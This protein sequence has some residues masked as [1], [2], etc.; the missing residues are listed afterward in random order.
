MAEFERALIQERVKAG[1]R[2]AQAKERASDGLAVLWMPLKLSPLRASGVSWRAIAQQLGVGIAT[3]Y[4]VIAPK[5]RP[6]YVRGRDLRRSMSTLQPRSADSFGSAVPRRNR[7]KRHLRSWHEPVALRISSQ[8]YREITT[9]HGGADAGLNIKQSPTSPPSWAYLLPSLSR[10]QSRAQ[11][12]V[13][14]RLQR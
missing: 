8:S 12:C 1:L 9:G 4:R 13:G 10:Q 6:R 3:L 11:L 2:N 5:Y 14:H 7:R